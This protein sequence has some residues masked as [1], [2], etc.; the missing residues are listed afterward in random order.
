MVIK[1]SF[2][3]PAFIKVV[4]T[5]KRWFVYYLVY[6]YLFHLVKKINYQTLLKI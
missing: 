5:L 2:I 3:F 1:E 4:Y 6:F